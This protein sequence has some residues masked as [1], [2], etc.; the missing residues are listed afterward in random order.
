MFSNISLTNISVKIYLVIIIIVFIYCIL[1]EREELGCTKV[2]IK[3]QCDELNS[4]YYKDSIPKPTDTRTILEYKLLRLL[5][6]YKFSNV[7]KKC[8]IIS[9]ILCIFIK[10]LT[11]VSNINI[12]SL[13][14]ITIAILYFYHNFMIYHV[15]RYARQIGTGIIIK[16]RDIDKK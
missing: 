13:H 7:W 5:S 9:T 14:L 10:L 12:I 8:F 6:L 1:Q 15:F 3:K 2:T 16:L 4:V 11:N